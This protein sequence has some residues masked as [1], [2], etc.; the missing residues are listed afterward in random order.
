MSQAVQDEAFVAQALVAAGV[1]DARVVAGPLKGALVDIW[2]AADTDTVPLE[3][4]P[5]PKGS[6]V[7]V[8]KVFNTSFLLRVC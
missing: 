8:L 4:I 7:R 3:T 1:V 5:H 6:R 2:W